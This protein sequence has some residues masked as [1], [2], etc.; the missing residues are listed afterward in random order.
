[1]YGDIDSVSGHGAAVS[2]RPHANGADL[3]LE[4]CHSFAAFL[5]DVETQKV[6]R[7]TATFNGD[8]GAVDLVPPADIPP[9]VYL[10]QIEYKDPAGNP[11]IYPSERK[12]V[13]WNISR[14]FSSGG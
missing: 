2:V 9:G 3:P 6:E 5:E 4:D 7:I 13:R 10:L 1:M 8:I 11:H 14:R 12:Q